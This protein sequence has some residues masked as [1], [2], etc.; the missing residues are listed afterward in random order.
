MSFVCSGR[1]LKKYCSPSC[2]VKSEE[3]QRKIENTTL[4]KHGVRNV[5]Q[6]SEVREKALESSRSSES[7]SKRKETSLKKWGVEN[8]MQNDGIKNKA[9]ERQRENNN[10]KL[11]F[12]GEDQRKTMID[13]YGGPSPMT[14]E[15]V[16][17]KVRE[18]QLKRNDGV[19]GFNNRKQKE[20]MLE[21]FGGFG[22]L[23]D[24]KEV[25]KMRI[26]SQENYG[27]D[28][29][30]KDPEVKERALSSIIEK[31]GYIFG[32]NSPISQTNIDFAEN[33][34][35][36][37]GV[38]VDFEFPLGGKIYDLYIESA[39]LLI[40][41]NPTVTHNSTMSFAC[42]RNSCSDNCEKHSPFPRNAHQEK[43]KIAR[44]NG[45]NLV[46]IFDWDDSEKIEKF[47]QA[48]LRKDSHRLSAHSCQVRTI[49]QKEANKFLDVNHIQGSARNQTHCYGLFSKTDEL[50]AV[51]T[52][53]KSRF[54]RKYE[55]EWIRYAIKRDFHIHGASAKIFEFFK[56]DV[57]PQSI[58]SYVDFNHTTLDTFLT[59]LSF[60]LVD[61]TSPDLSWFSKKRNL[62]VRQTSLN[63][64]GADRLL[65]TSYGKPE[66][67][68]MNNREIMLKEGFLEVYSS[69]NLVY[70]WEKGLPSVDKIS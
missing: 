54:N 41:L 53:G 66:E 38:T 65:G 4:E 50:L 34:K 30:M 67:C 3:T 2:A 19:W 21:R 58:I 17:N 12:N 1:T 59:S 46:Q 63:T 48:K 11:A 18:T 62:R 13:R 7:L 43:A 42:L 57:D 68:G 36:R 49:S 60:K 70:T 35:N 56:S 47:L 20:T 51:A 37:F 31:N 5:F 14:S 52:F 27:V 23:S 69:G 44:E 26:F 61:I 22:R 29:P 32:S 10:G 55:Y 40:E 24:P 8:P 33:I 28:W 25:E 39:N 64:L 16:R 15:E 6:K 9:L 45:Y